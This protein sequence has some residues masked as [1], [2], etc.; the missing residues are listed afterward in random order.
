MTKTKNKTRKIM[1]L[2]LALILALTAVVFS[3]VAT[4][5]NILDAN[6][7]NGLPAIHYNRF[8]QVDYFMQ[9]SGREPW[10]A[11]S[12]QLA[13]DSVLF[14]QVCT[15]NNKLLIE[16]DSYPLT[17]TN[18]KLLIWL[19][20]LDTGIEQFYFTEYQY[21]FYA[22]GIPFFTA[23]FVMADIF[24][25]QGVYELT[26]YEI[27]LGSFPHSHRAVS[28]AYDTRYFLYNSIPLPPDPMPDA[29]FAFNGWYLDSSFTSPVPYRH[30]ITAN[31]R[32]Y[33]RFDAIAYKITFSLNNGVFA[34]APP[35]TFTVL[36]TVALP[37]P[38]R[39]GHNF[40]GWYTNEN[41]SGN[42]VTHIEVGTYRNRYFYARWAPMLFRVE[43]VV[44]GTVWRYDYVEF[45]SSLV[46]FNRFGILDNIE[47]FLDEDFREP[48]NFEEIIV[49]DN[50]RLFSFEIP[51]LAWWQILI[52]AV[53]GLG[54]IIL[55]LNLVGIIV[56]KVRGK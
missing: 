37:I 38:S 31:T 29:G 25:L 35:T 34:V 18:I 44:N 51:R 47:W 2:A 22:G 20:C 32:L 27:S 17:F 36:D 48:I 42:S 33:A 53:L 46:G 19:T 5:Q 24:T 40:L 1:V 28:Y 52:G 9:Y 16:R 15:I 39:T 14:V 12:W 8:I 13:L 26:V 3:A 56:R 4:R 11:N 21:F 50:I 41:F 30:P 7:N 45:G 10:I 6:A 55:A 54:M 23:E 49:E 43:F